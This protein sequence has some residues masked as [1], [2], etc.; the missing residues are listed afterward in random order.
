MVILHKTDLPYFPPVENANEEGLLA[1]GGKLTIDWLLEAYSHGIFPWFNDDRAPV[2][3]WS[4]DPR[5]VM[6]PQD[7][8][9]QKSMR[10]FFNQKKYELKI[11]T[12]FEDVIEMCKKIKRKHEK[13]TWITRRMTE[14]YIDLHKKGFAHSF[15]AWKDNR[16]VGGLYG[17][18]LG[19]M[20]FGESMFAVLPN[21]SKYAFISMCK[22]LEKNNFNLIDCQM[23]TEHLKFMG[24]GSIKR[25]EF[26]KLLTDNRKYLT[27]IGN[28]GNILKR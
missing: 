4:P 27:I 3:W 15:E 13:G 26:V 12:A 25:S 24:C 10:P 5:A 7:V 23:E 22:I 9:I 11:D 19:R 18:S 1:I 21:A 14:A 16:L 28:W 8:K 2:L 20:F 6:K 17:I